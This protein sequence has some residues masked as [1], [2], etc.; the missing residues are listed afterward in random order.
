MSIPITGE[1]ILLFLAILGP[2]AG[3]WWRLEARLTMQDEA[4]SELAKELND[5]KYFVAQNHVTSAAL[6]K[7]EDRIMSAFAKL[8]SQLE[9][10][11]AR[12][13]RP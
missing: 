11:N 4:R 6:Q 5:Y 9:K 12:T 10:L 3:L 8:E 7:T 1:I 13:P 2:I